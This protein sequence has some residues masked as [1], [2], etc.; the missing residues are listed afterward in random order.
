MTQRGRAPDRRARGVRASR[1]VLLIS[2]LVSTLSI[3]VAPNARAASGDL[4]PSFGSTGW[5]ELAVY[6]D[7]AGTGL[8]IQDDG[9]VLV[10]IGSPWSNLFAVARLLPDGTPDPSFGGDGYVR[11]GFWRRNSGSNASSSTR[12]SRSFGT[13]R[14]A[15]CSSVGATSTTVAPRSTVGANTPRPARH[16]TPSRR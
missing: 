12:P 8:A 5:L 6:K 13:G 9:K 2:A 14:P 16:S 1:H 3:A 10:S 15:A 4:D 11:T 7:P